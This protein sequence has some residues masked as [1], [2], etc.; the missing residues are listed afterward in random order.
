LNFSLY[1][2]LVKNAALYF[3][4]NRH[5]FQVTRCW[6]YACNTWLLQ[7]WRLVQALRLFQCLK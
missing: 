3:Y 7:Y 1:P 2:F 4:K 6:T 5:S